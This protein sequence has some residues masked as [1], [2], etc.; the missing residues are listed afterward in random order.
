M[1]EV[2]LEVE[3]ELLEVLELEV[4]QQYLEPQSISLSNTYIKARCGLPMPG[5]SPSATDNTVIAVPQGG[6]SSIGSH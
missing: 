5:Y 6:L 2:L 3:L 1:L 4:L